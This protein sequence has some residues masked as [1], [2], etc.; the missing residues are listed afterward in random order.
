ML[1]KNQQKN[2]NLKL[3]QI[4]NGT[5]FIKYEE[6]APGS[7]KEARTPAKEKDMNPLLLRE[8]CLTEH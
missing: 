8:T 2:P 6:G 3:H 5:F 1:L 7:E 4:D